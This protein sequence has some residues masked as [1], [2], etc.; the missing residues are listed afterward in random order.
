M[1]KHISKLILAVFC[2]TALVSCTEDILTDPKPT[3]SV[4][5]EVIFNSREGAEAFISGILRRFRAQ[6]TSTDAAG[7]N[8][9]FFAR[10]MKGNDV[11]QA[12]NWFGFDYS[13]DN[14][15]PTYRRTVFN[16]EFPYYIIN[17]ANTLVNGVNESGAIPEE[18]KVELVAQGRAMRAFMYFQ[19]A[20]EY[21][22]TYAYDPSLPAPP[23]Y[24][25]LS[26]E[27]KPMSTLQEV[28]N[29]I[30]DDLT[31]AV[32]NLD[33]YRLGKSYVNQNVANAILAQVYQVTENWEGAR[34]AAIAAYGGDPLS[35]LDAAGYAGGFSDIT[36]IEWI[37]AAPQSTDQS[38]YY[39]G[40][41]H[42]MADHY[43]LSYQ[44]TFFNNDF[45]NLFSTSDV[46]NLFVNGYGVPDADYRHYITTKFTFNFDSDFAYIRTPEM[47][48]IEAEANYR[49]GDEAKAHDLLYTIQS[50]RDPNAVKSS[51]SGSALFEEILVER[52][53]EL[54]AEN[55]VE[56]FD[57]KRLQRG[58]TRT[59]NHRI[60]ESASLSP[61]DNRFFLKIPQEEIDANVNIDDN[62]N[63][64]R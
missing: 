25:E 41:P 54:Y 59:G 64:G 12:N 35:V 28:Y 23:I 17:Q 33:D 10:A 46:R 18:D 2:A 63:A 31:Y 21:Q 55:G 32:D 52:R 38:N 3:E 15:E 51:N 42:S 9:I 11:I 7:V 58:I 4:T 45:V 29:L 44:A 56:W 26:L 6:F 50:N 34:A 61:N 20:M 19:L 60:K 14:R 1:K 8:S 40:A 48:L 47:I 30:I 22:H 62:V 57:A 39:W 16:W 49:L 27:G 36:N 24:L 43:T 53:K 37:W 5:A 13:N